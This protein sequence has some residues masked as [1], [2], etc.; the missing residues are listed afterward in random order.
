MGE[1][2]SKVKRDHTKGERLGL[3]GRLA[4][5]EVWEGPEEQRQSIPE[6]RCLQVRGTWPARLP[7]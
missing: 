5:V 6:V 7:R 1:I 4:A 3:P 2:I